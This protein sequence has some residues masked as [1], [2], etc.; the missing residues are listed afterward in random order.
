MNHEPT[1]QIPPDDPPAIRP[2]VGR[3]V[4][5][6]LLALFTCGLLLIDW[7]SLLSFQ[8]VMQYRG[9]AVAVNRALTYPDDRFYTG[10]VALTGVCIWTLILDGWTL[11][12][13]PSRWTTIAYRAVGIGIGICGLLL[14]YAV[15]Q[16]G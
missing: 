11:R 13:A 10:I 5:L 12:R 3:I 6:S 7:G 1:Y 15:A 14:L 9:I 4:R 2:S 16:I 8:T